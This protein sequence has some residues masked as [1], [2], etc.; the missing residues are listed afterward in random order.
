MRESRRREGRSGGGVRGLWSSPAEAAAAGAPPRACTSRDADGG[1][2][3]QSCWKRCR[4]PTSAS[5]GVPALG[6]TGARRKGL[7]KQRRQGV[8]GGGVV[9]RRGDPATPWRSTAQRR[10]RQHVPSP[11]TAA[12]IRCRCCLLALQPPCRLLLLGRLATRQLLSWAAT[13]TQAREPLL[14]RWRA[15]A[16]R[17]G[18]DVGDPALPVAPGVC[19][20]ATGCHSYAQ[21]C[22]TV[23][24]CCSAP[25]PHCAAIP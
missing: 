18:V 9:Q 23:A 2:G 24:W 22:A 3:L 1:S 7:G 12:T 21:M 11:C 15:G 16:R 13:M 6:G 19:T 4:S 25:R 10:G 20:A 8:A 14:G 5:A 17:C